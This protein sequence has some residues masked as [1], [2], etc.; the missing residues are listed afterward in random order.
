MNLRDVP[1]SL[2][3]W[4][5]DVWLQSVTQDRVA[6]NPNSVHGSVHK[7]GVPSG[8]SDHISQLCPSVSLNSVIVSLRPC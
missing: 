3:P 8:F 2:A 7:A 5:G 4:C 1:P 6:R